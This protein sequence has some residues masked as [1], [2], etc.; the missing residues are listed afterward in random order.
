MVDAVGLLSRVP[1]YSGMVPDVGA[2]LEKVAR[3]KQMQTQGALAGLQLQEGQ[4]RQGALSAFRANPG[5][6]SVLA[7]HPE[8]YHQVL[9]NQSSKEDFSTQQNARDAAELLAIQDPAQRS[10]AWREKLATGAQQGRFPGLVAHQLSQ[11]QPT[12]ELLRGFISRALPPSAQMP[13]IHVTDTNPISGT[14]TY[15]WVNPVQRTVDPLQPSGTTASGGGQQMG[16]RQQHEELMGLK[17]PA[18]M[19]KLKEMD[20]GTASQ[21][22]QMIDGKIPY[23]G[24]QSRDARAKTLAWMASKVDDSLDATRFQTRQKLM[25]TFAAGPVSEQIKSLNTVP[26]HLEDLY[27]AAT[28][29]NNSTYFPGVTNTIGNVV[30]RQVNPK[31]Q[32]ALKNFEPAKNAVAGEMAKVFRASGMSVSEIDEW[33]KTF[34]ATDSPGELHSAIRKAVSLIDS[35][36][37]A[38]E[39]QW[40]EGVGWTTNDK[41]EVVPKEAFTKISPEAKAVFARLRES[42]P[43]KALPERLTARKGEKADN[44]PLPQTQTGPPPNAAKLMD[45]VRAGAKEVTLP[46]GRV[47]SAQEYTDAYNQKYGAPK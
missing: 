37:H 24:T 4:Q 29:L 23:P 42:E 8:L 3:I 27:D 25:N 17:G 14:P 39:H 47:L 2:Q 13:S 9:Q 20:S 12:D 21:V 45:Q 26:K 22:Q 41:G 19:E 34:D 33:K 16:T 38:I 30:G 5:D 18:F 31:V 44:G 36:T 1:D 46:S 10:Q 32:N 43:G 6:P 7:G 28:A 40:G 35:R 11:Q 15:S